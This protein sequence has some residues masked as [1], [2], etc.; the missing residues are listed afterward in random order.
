MGDAVSRPAGTRRRGAALE[1]VILEAAWEELKEVGFANLTVA[2]VAVRARTGKQVLYRRW[3]NR[4]W[5][6]LAAINHHAEPPL[7]VPEDTGSLRGD[8]LALLDV[9]ARRLD[10]FDPSLLRTILAEEDG[11]Q[12]GPSSSAVAHLIAAGPLVKVLIQRAV[13][14]GELSDAPIPERVLDVVATLGRHEFMIAARP[15]DG[16]SVA[17]VLRR[18]FTEMVDQVILPLLLAYA[19]PTE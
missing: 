8:I 11:A 13:A 4:A 12:D 15:D 17:D 6:A 5:L 7:A 1:E 10:G 18:P 14:R 19:P 9:A 2:N 16:S 3:P